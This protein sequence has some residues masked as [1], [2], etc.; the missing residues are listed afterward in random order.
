MELAAETVG[1]TL[2]PVP[3]NILLA[4]L[5]VLSKNTEEDPDNPFQ[6]NPYTIWLDID[7]GVKLC[8]P[9]VEYLKSPEP[10][11][12]PATRTVSLPVN[13]DLM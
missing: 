7:I 13:T 6:P 11:A 12:L 5:N 8:P 4:E 10:P 2:D 3:L 9:S 1:E